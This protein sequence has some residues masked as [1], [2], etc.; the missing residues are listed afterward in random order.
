M[1]VHVV[2]APSPDDMPEL[3]IKLPANRHRYFDLGHN[4]EDL[5]RKIEEK[6]E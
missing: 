5:E 3:C 2:E 1:S 4:P 6:D